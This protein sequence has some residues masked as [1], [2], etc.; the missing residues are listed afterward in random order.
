MGQVPLGETAEVDLN[1]LS[2]LSESKRCSS[3]RLMAWLGEDF[4]YPSYREGLPT[5][6]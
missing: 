6:V 1:R 2:L 5:T 4:K 3:R